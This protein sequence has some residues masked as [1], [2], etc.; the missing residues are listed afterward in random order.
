MKKTIFPQDQ[1]FWYLKRPDILPLKEDKKT[2]VVVIGGGMAGLTAAQAFAQKGKKV[3]LLEAFYCG[4]G[5]S[6]KSSGFITPNG[7]ISLSEFVYRYGI[8]GGKMIWDSIEKQGLEHIRNNIKQYQIDC[9]YV[10]ADSLEVASS[11]KDLK[12]IIKEAE[13][14]AKF[15][16]ETNFIKKEDL[17]LILG[18]K[19]YYGGVTYPKSFGINA[20]KYC[21]A[22]K[23][24]LLASGVEIYEETPVLSMEE[25]MV[26]TLHATVKA[27]YIIVCTDRFIP[28]LGKLTKEIYHVQNFLL[29]SETLTQDVIKKM[30]PQKQFMVWDTDLIYSFYR[31]TGDRLLLGGGSVF[32]TYNTY[33]THHSNYMHNK[34]TNYIADIFPDI[35]IQFEQMW[36]GLIGVSKDIAPIA[37]RDKDSQSIYYI[38][39]AAGLTL[40]AMLGNYCA[41]H[42][43]DDADTL[44]DYFSPYRKF[45]VGG[46]LQTVLG[47]K[48]SFAIANWVSHGNT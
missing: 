12:D 38:G 46:A 26:T 18:S 1:N 3:V 23:T 2:D 20:Y 7:E 19:K 24:I 10:E 8:E 36:P 21:Q 28:T 17:P 4:A 37:G 44:K 39:A 29:L 9:D 41:E 13:N 34:L 27:D 40:A 6:G 16:Y 35:E 15:G 5:A 42:M 45:P 48:A 33:E 25:H 31:M 47:T 43:L 11:Q 30:F 14:L 22:M 32:N